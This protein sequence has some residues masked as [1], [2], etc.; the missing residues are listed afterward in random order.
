MVVN[1]GFP[2]GPPHVRDPWT[3]PLFKLYGCHLLFLES[4]HSF[5]WVNSHTV[6]KRNPP[7]RQWRWSRPTMVR[8]LLV[9]LNPKEEESHDP[10]LTGR[11]RSINLGCVFLNS[12]YHCD[13]DDGSLADNVLLS[14]L[15]SRW[16]KQ[17]TT[18]NNTFLVSEK[19]IRT[20]TMKAIKAM[21]RNLDPQ[22]PRSHLSRVWLACF[23]GQQATLTIGFR[24]L[25]VRLVLPKS[26][27]SVI[28]SR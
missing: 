12:K 3:V 2:H 8:L 16:G 27:V 7:H 23:R 18:T 19:I 25:W 13:D 5:A 24:V 15:S 4:K 6:F 20:T 1:G 21:G 17:K 26:P 28:G 10:H 9:N 22:C 11:P 14:I